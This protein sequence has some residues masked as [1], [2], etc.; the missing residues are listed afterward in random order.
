MSGLPCS[1]ALG[2]SLIK[3]L[4]LIKIINNKPGFKKSRESLTRYGN[5]YKDSHDTDYNGVLAPDDTL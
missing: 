3:H 4:K 2:D 1:G 5:W